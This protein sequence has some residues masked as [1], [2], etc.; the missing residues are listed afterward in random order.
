[1]EGLGRPAS[2]RIAGR[3]LFSGIDCIIT[4]MPDTEVKELTSH[5]ARAQHHTGSGGCFLIVFSLPFIAV[6][7]GAL[8]AA[9]GVFLPSK[10]NAPPLVIGCV[11]AV[12][13]G[14]GLL[15]MYGGI[16]NTLISA[17]RKREQQMFPNEP[18]RR[19]HVWSHDGAVDSSIAKGWG[20]LCA[21]GFV[22]V[23]M[24]PFNYWAFFTKES[25]VI[26]IGITSLFD[27]IAIAIFCGG[28]YQ[29]L[30]GM[31]YGASRLRWERFPF[32]LGDVFEARFATGRPIGQFNAMTITLRCIVEVTETRG[33][34]KSRSQQIVCYQHYADTVEIKQAGVH[35]LG[36][37]PITFNLPQG[38][39]G[40]TLGIA[41][42]RYWELEINADTPGID[43]HASFMVPV[44]KKN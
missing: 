44:Y 16:R 7:A 39:Y 11:G 30:R 1:M 27:L 38:D 24:V 3:L 17:R 32:F 22:A 34:G 23:F 4:A 6:G 43:F 37:V 42:P 40:T 2:E 25:H 12:F 13:A 29:I 31:K 21:G 20:T 18:W 19:D 5:V 35:G 26:V 36:E 14:A 9:F 10:M 33:S 41:R 28:M 8:L 15:V